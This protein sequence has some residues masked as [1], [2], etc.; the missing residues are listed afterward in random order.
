MRLMRARGNSNFGE[1]M[2]RDRWKMMKVWPGLMAV[3]MVGSPAGAGDPE[4]ETGGSRS[5][6]SGVTQARTALQSMESA[7]EAEIDAWRE[8]VLRSQRKL[9]ESERLSNR[10]EMERRR[11]EEALADKEAII[12][13]L[14][15]AVEAL[16][17][18]LVREGAAIEGR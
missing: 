16:S 2:M 10:R 3:V 4:T 11:L 7:H 14:E 9:V 8:L 6:E 15:A 12:A 1:G 5:F 18:R 17:A 13:D